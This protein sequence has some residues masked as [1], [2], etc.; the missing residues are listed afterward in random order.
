MM[1]RGRNIGTGR[2]SKWRRAIPE[3]SLEEASMARTSTTNMKNSI[4]T[5]GHHI[6]KVSMTGTMSMTMI[7]EMTTTTP[8]IP[9]G[10]A[11][12][13]ENI[14]RSHTLTKNNHIN[15]E[16]RRISQSI[17]HQPT[18]IYSMAR[19]EDIQNNNINNQDPRKTNIKT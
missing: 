10:R 6:V 15:T 19:I 16:F 5:R 8:K 3:R 1:M 9:H 13:T 4:L 2:S 18:T 17:I 14:Q 7:S 11:D 12:P